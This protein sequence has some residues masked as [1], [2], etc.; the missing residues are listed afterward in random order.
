MDMPGMTLPRQIKRFDLHDQPAPSLRRSTRIRRPP[1]RFGDCVSLTFFLCPHE[2]LAY[3]TL[4][5]AG[6]IV[7]NV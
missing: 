4:N 7:V 5:L 3:R 1:D 6:R 2:R